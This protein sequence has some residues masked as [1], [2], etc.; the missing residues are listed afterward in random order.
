MTLLSL[1]S[2]YIGANLNKDVS[3]TMYLSVGYLII[4]C[5][6]KK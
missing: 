5:C 6:F 1:T 4:T 3:Q 2:I